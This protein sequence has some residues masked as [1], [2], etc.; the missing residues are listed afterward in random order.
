M[1]KA[2]KNKKVK[3]GGS[4]AYR[5]IYA[6]LAGIVG[7]IF[8]YKVINR[9]KE[10]DEGRCI[11]CANHVSATDAIALCYAFRKNQVCFMAK[12][13]LFKVP[14]LGRLIRAL[15]AVPLNRKGADIS[16]IKTSI[17]LVEGGDLISIFLD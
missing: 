16:A 6:L 2:K 9:E 5:I 3:K 10:P 8:N 15:G 1:A 14:L 4:R 13:E 7:R 12:K 17:S 11:V